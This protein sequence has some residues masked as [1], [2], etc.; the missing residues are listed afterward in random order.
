MSTVTVTATT[1]MP[2]G[3]GQAR[4]SPFTLVARSPPGGVT[5]IGRAF[6]AYRGI[7]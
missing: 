2:N 3:A 4:L 5:G 6:I 1:M 7:S